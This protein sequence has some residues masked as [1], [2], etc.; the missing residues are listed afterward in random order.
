MT[1]ESVGRKCKIKHEKEQMLCSL[2]MPLNYG[3]HS[4]LLLRREKPVNPEAT[5]NI[6]MFKIPQDRRL[7]KIGAQTNL[8]DV[9]KTA[10][11]T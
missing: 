4:I 7:L 9:E 8:P 6:T 10:F 3:K 1:P 5:L 11:S 2:Q